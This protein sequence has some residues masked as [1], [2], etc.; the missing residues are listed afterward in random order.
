MSRSLLR[1]IFT[2]RSS[3]SLDSSEERTDLQACL[4]D[5]SMWLNLLIDLPS[6]LFRHSVDVRQCWTDPLTLSSIWNLFLCEQSSIQWEEIT[7]H[8]T[9]VQMKRNPHWP[10]HLSFAIVSVGFFCRS[11]I[12][13]L[14]FDLHKKSFFFFILNF[15]KILQISNREIV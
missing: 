12:D 4:K 9:Y 15:E 6:Q 11:S 10:V 2:L 7:D 5:I 14:Q 8:R 13:H 1:K 3:V